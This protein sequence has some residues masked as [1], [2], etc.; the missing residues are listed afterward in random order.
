M[1][2]KFDNARQVRVGYNGS[3]IETS[4]GEL[5]WAGFNKYGALGVLGYQSCTDELFELYPVQYH[6]PISWDM[7]FYG[8]M[9]ACNDGKTFGA[10]NAT[11]YSE[12]VGY[13]D[14]YQF[15]E[16]TEL[17]EVT[18][19]TVGTYAAFAKAYDGY[20]WGGGQNND[21]ELGKSGSDF[22]KIWY[23]N[24]FTH[25]TSS[26][27]NSYAIDI[28]GDLYSAGGY[29]RLFESGE[30]GDRNRLNVRYNFLAIEALPDL[31]PVNASYTP[32]HRGVLGNNFD[33][34]EFHDQVIGSG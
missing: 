27:N 19:V 4:S 6:N 33:I 34:K 21:G 9:I 24:K 15:V 31:P 16:I 7:R 32:I 25:M 22:S 12:V 2:A 13:V 10:G 18:K 11:K 8:V 20:W 3:I 1:D 17:S 23:S 29:Q 28:S 30:T 26:W 5:W 14:Q